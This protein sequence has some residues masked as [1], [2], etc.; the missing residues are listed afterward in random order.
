MADYTNS[1]FSVGAVM[2]ENAV[3]TTFPSMEP[4]ITPE[5]LKMRH[6]LG[7]SL[8]TAKDPLTGKATIITDDILADA[9]EG[10]VASAELELK[11]DIFPVKR[12]EKQPFD[13]NLYQSFGYFQLSHR[14]CSS[15]DKMSVTPSNQL[16]IYVVP[17]EWVETAYLARGQVN[18][19][20]LTIAFVQGT[21]IPQQSAGG[22]AFLQILGNKPWIPAW[23]QIEYTSGFPNGML[24]R[25]LN[26]YI[27]SRA[28][29]E[30]LSQ[31]AL[32]FARANSQSLG[33]DG[34][35]QSVSTPGP[36][37][38]KGRI[39]ELEEKMKAIGKK[40]KALFGFKIYSG[41]I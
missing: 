33:I 12:R 3:Q 11:I 6:L 34:L 40:V 32:S 22:A 10:A 2:P 36:Q 27:G 5:L 20:P 19:V 8:A 31:L 26:E 21:Y 29:V 17:N 23:W 7:V 35:S 38:F 28:A 1:R 39:D 9:I 14:P 25:I 4:L 24:P 18:I 13:L 15:L 41:T 16:D 37:I 30:I